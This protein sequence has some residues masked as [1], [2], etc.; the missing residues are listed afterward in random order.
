M[1]RIELV[2]LAKKMGIKHSGVRKAD[3]ESSILSHP[4]YNSVQEAEAEEALADSGPPTPV[5]EPEVKPKQRRKRATAEDQVPKPTTR[6][7]K[8]TAWTA[9]ISSYMAEHKCSLK[10]ASAQKEAYQKFK[11]TY[12]KDK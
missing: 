2:E 9:F 7:R 12:N 4:D 5:A 10:E 1:K 3:L 6:P 8:A 11:E